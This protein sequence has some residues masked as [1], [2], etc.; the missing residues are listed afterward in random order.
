[1]REFLADADREQFVVL[2]VNTRND[3]LGYNVVS[4][5]SVNASIVHPREVFKAAI[6]LNAA[7]I[8]IAHNHPSGDPAPSREDREVTRAISEAG[9]PRH[10]PPR[11]RDRRG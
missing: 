9:R 10:P 4:V 7:S 11:P 1:M 8:V 2:C 3:L 6:L 5:G